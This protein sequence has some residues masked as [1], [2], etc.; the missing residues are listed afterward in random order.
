MREKSERNLGNAETPLLFDRYDVK[1]SSNCR[2]R[3][4]R[5]SLR[6]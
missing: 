5:P 2:V 1:L 4:L 3:S 6:R